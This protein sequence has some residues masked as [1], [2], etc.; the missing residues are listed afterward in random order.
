[1]LFDDWDDDDCPLESISREAPFKFKDETQIIY[2]QSSFYA[3]S[4]RK[5]PCLWQFGAPEGYGFKFV[6][7]VLNIVY[8]V[9]LKIENSTE[10]IRT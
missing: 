6:V 10:V 1:M 2:L 4:T 8:P 9:Q 7:E 5:H 3:N